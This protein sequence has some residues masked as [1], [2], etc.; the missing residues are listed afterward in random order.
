MRISEKTEKMKKIVFLINY[1]FLLDP[2]M[3]KI[4]QSKNVKILILI[5]VQFFN[6]SC[7]T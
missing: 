5:D 7:S 6:T 3:K 2:P 1:H 4:K